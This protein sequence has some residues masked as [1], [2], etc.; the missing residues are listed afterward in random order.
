MTIIV[1]LIIVIIGIGIIWVMRISN[2]EFEK[3][4]LKV[5]QYDLACERIKEMIMNLPRTV[6]SYNEI[7]HYFEEIYCVPYGADCMKRQQLYM[8]FVYYYKDIMVIV[9]SRQSEDH[10]FD[11]SQTFSIN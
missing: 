4:S 3:M 7:A 1:L 5:K 2:K 9:A 8:L 10:E 6:K 11:P